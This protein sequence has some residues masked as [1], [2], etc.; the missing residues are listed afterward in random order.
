MIR[1]LVCLMV[2][3]L[4]PQLTLAESD[5]YPYVTSNNIAANSWHPAPLRPYERFDTSRQTV[6]TRGL[7]GLVAA[8]GPSAALLIPASVLP[9]R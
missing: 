6:N 1:S 4:A 3:L 2:P 8:L 7:L 5:P 9:V